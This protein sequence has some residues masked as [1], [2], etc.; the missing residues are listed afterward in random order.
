MPAYERRQSENAAL[1]LKIDRLQAANRQLKDAVDLMGQRATDWA[2]Q[3]GSS[4]MPEARQSL[5]ELQTLYKSQRAAFQ[6]ATQE[7][8]H[9]YRVD[10]T[11]DTPLLSPEEM[12][13]LRAIQI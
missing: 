11:Q 8:T 1:R 12:A 7:G 5:N 4:P 3:H 13:A 2:R 10:L 6:M 9:A